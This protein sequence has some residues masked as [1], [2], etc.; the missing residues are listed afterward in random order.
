[1][2]RNVAEFEA[3]TGKD[4]PTTAEHQLIAATRA[5][6]P[7]VL[8]D[9]ASPS[10]PEK[11]G[12]K[13]RIR[14]S[15]LRLLI[16]GGTPNCGL[17]ERGVTLAGGWIEGALDLAYCTARGQTLLNF[18]C[19]TDQPSFYNAHLRQLDLDDSAFPG[20]MA[21]GVRIDAS[22]F[23]RRIAAKG[24]V[25]VG[26]AEIGRQLACN[27]AR[28][29]GAGGKALHAQ[30]VKVGADLFLSNLT[31]KGTVDVNGA[32]IG[33][34][35]DCHGARL[36]GAGG[37]AL[38]A[39]GVKVGANF[40]LS[41]LTAKGTVTVNGAEIGGQL[42]C[43][44]ARLHGAGS[45]ALNAQAVKVRDSLFLRNLA[46]KG[47]VDVSGAEIVGQVDCIGARLHGAGG[48]ALN[49]QRLQVTQSFLF[50]H[51]AAPPIGRIDLNGALVGD[52]VDD[53]AS[54]PLAPDN[55]VLDGF[56]YDRIG[57]GNNTSFAARR[58]WLEAGS[59]W[60]GEFLPQPYTQLAKVLRQM[61][62]VGEARKVLI[63]REHRLAQHRLAEERA[64]YL[65]A[66]DGGPME[67][68]DTG[69]IWLRM[70]L[71]RL[72]FW[73]NRIV[74]GYGYAPQR[75]VYL[76]LAVTCVSMIA[77]FFFWRLGGMVPSDAVV[78]TSPAW[79]EAVAANPGAPALVWA[80]P[81][82]THYERRLYT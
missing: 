22:L 32:E 74:T 4:K 27:G 79:A 40:F 57:G 78:L 45:M 76:S 1:M 46:A 55:L 36:H 50:R 64:A 70:T 48:K 21:Q 42:A 33:G 9:P 68:G 71:S 16:L 14:A 67:K 56:T 8:C 35:L 59:T 61:G 39:Q 81:A 38:H 6:V 24:T 72:W 54:W 43:D 75:A 17:H 30:G 29:H 51:L 23:L 63:E 69:W 7:C 52:L 11:A 58:R 3:L 13:T 80:G 15:L 5:G 60:N 82:A 20:L 65:A 62:H 47:A 26:G 2:F 37:M 10:R 12:D 66:R 44:G 19:F 49:A 77:Y 18:C 31:A 53:A 73:L 28:I 41:N 34:Q 25:D